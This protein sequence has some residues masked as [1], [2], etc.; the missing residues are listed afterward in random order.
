MFI[1]HVRW[2]RDEDTNDIRVCYKYS[3]MRSH[4]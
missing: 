2:G 3:N 4:S 1:M